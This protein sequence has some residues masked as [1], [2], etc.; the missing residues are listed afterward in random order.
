LLA[1]YCRDVEAVL[2]QLAV[3]GKTNEHKTALENCPGVPGFRW[4]SS[5][6]VGTRLTLHL[7]QTAGLLVY[8]PSLAVHLS[9]NATQ[10]VV[11]RSTSALL[12]YS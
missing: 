5:R 10:Q 9:A 11:H 7:Q 6:S 4:T 2:A 1:A 8:P 3:P 12:A